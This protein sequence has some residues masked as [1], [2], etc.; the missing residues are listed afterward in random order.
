MFRAVFEASGDGHS[1]RRRS[2]ATQVKLSRA[3]YLPAYNEI[4][5]LKILQFHIYDR[6]VEYFPVDRPQ[7]VGHFRKRLALYPY[8][9]HA[10]KCNV[11]IGLDGHGLIE[12]RREWKA[13]LQHICRINLIA[14]VAMLQ[15]CRLLV[16]TSSVFV[17]A[18]D[19]L[20]RTCRGARR[21][22]FLSPGGSYSSY[23]KDES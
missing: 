23:K 9:F 16:I 21:T 5:L 6:I 19:R 1:F 15:C 8:A 13:Q 18:D 17:L 2:L 12:F 11:T 22:S 7:R 4:G 20:C 10:T 14:P 3:P